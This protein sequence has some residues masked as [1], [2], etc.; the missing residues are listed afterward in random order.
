MRAAEQ[1]VLMHA[2][3]MATLL[4]EREAGKMATMGGVKEDWTTEVSILKCTELPYTITLLR[5]IVCTNG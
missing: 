2:P 3:K 1:S 4:N 5:S